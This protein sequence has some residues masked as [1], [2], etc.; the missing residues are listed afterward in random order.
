MI[1]FNR[2][3]VIIF[4]LTHRF[5]L[6]RDIRISYLIKMNRWTSFDGGN[7]I[8]KRTDIRNTKIGYGTYLG[9]DCDLVSGSIGKFCSIAPFVKCIYGTHPLS[10]FVS[11]HPAFF[12]L[13]KQSGFTFVTEP[14]FI[15]NKL[16]EKGCSFEIGNDVW[17]GYDVKI[18]EGVSIG[19]GAVIAT[20]AVVTKD[21]PS[22]EIWGGIPARKIR[23]RFSNDVKEKLLKIKWWNK[24]IGELKGQVDLFDDVDA[25]INANS[26]M[27]K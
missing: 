20:G 4:S 8:H 5:I 11:S 15:E 23:D 22:Y 1:L 7:R 10:P 16:T 19:D 3:Y 26:T 14:R 6:N 25:F 18:S 12:S 24:D 21:V 9:W 27:E 2:I 13:R 17:I